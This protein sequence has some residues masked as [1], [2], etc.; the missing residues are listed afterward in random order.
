VSAGELGQ[1][2]QALALP[3]PRKVSRPRTRKK[4]KAGT[5]PSAKRVRVWQRRRQWA[6]EAEQLRQERLNGTWVRTLRAQQESRTL[7]GDRLLFPHYLPGLLR[8]TRST[9]AI[10]I[11]GWVAFAWQLHGHAQLV[12][13]Y[14]ELA[15]L[16]GCHPKTVEKWV[17]R[18]VE[19]GWIAPAYHFDDRKGCTW[20]ECNS[21][22]PGFAMRVELAAASDGRRR[23]QS[24]AFFV[25][26]SQDPTK[27]GS[28]VSLPERADT[29]LRARERQ[30]EREPSEQAEEVLSAPTGASVP[31]P[32][33]VPDATDGLTREVV[34]EAPASEPAPPDACATL[35][36]LDQAPPNATPEVSDGAEAASDPGASGEAAPPPPARVRPPPAFPGRTVRVSQLIEHQVASGAT[37][38]ADW[39]RLIRDGLLGTNDDRERGPPLRRRR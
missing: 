33:A 23:G 17:L 8:F 14:G 39:L 29:A 18:L 16:L 30:D 5:P 3:G 31:G 11:A 34:A 38:P 1:V 4:I 20:Q 10:Q 27:R 35:A 32:A 28:V 19:A 7:R 37:S 26:G 21:Y 9:Y 6:K 24:A 2:Q 22:S 13:S 15:G 36:T 25:P 12:G